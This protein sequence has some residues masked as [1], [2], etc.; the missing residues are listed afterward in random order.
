MAARYKTPMKHTFN[1]WKRF[2]LLFLLHGFFML[3]NS[4]S[5]RAQVTTGT[6]Q[7]SNKKAFTFYIPNA[8]SPNGDGINDEFFGKGESIMEYDIWIF[9]RWGNLIF[10]G[11]DLNAKWDGRANGGN[12]IAKQDVYVWKVRLTDVF[13][14]KHDYL[15]T[16]TL[17]K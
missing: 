1:V 14:K 5:I 4:S 7:E 17:V 16:V 3:Y 8:F 9:D 13:L 6:Q 11:K 10:S 2:K 12:E 15:G